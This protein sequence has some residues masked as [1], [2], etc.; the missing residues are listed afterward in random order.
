MKAFL[1]ILLFGFALLVLVAALAL[2][3][4]L[5]A[6]DDLGKVAHL[7]EPAGDGSPPD[8]TVTVQYLGNTNLLFSD[9]KTAILTD[10]WF[11]RPGTFR[12]L[13]G[14]IEPD[15]QAID[16]A[17]ARAGIDRLAAIIPVHSHYDHAMDSPLV[18]ERTNAVVVGSE[19]TLN[20]ARGLGFDETR[21]RQVGDRAEFSF[22]DFTV[23]LLKSR[24]FEF[25]PGLL[26]GQDSDSETIDAPL[27]PPA[28][29]FDY[30]MG[31]AYSILV[32]HPQGTALVQGSAGYVEGLLEGR[33]AD[34]AFLGVAGLMEKDTAYRDAYWTHVVE[35]VGAR[36][37]VP[38]HWDSFTHPLTD[39]PQL[40]SLLL[41][42]VLG[43]GAI[44][45]I[46]W[47]ES[48]ADAEGRRTALLPMWKKI[49][50]YKD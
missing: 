6:Q 4:L 40:P 15:E 27:V 25:P 50:I 32:A 20:I 31:G 37:I 44:G 10:G 29:A 41:D 7:F 8:G 17:L 26:G 24:H 18:A 5:H 34:V 39:E 48:E 36:K 9:G 13:F 43:L 28:S 19:S 16:A 45:G 12:T 46:R 21:L 49:N 30:R 23:T 22:G 42:R 3:Y 33:T 11:T 14:R 38:V 2:A 35:A 47:A 1:K